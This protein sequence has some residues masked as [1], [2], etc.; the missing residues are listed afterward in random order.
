MSRLSSKEKQTMMSTVYASRQS[1]SPG[2]SSAE[3]EEHRSIPDEEYEEQPEQ[4]NPRRSGVPQLARV[5]PNKSQ[6]SRSQSRKDDCPP[7]RHSPSRRSPSRQ[8]PSQHSS[9]RQTESRKIEHSPR[10]RNSD[11]ENSDRCD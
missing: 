3:Y 2:Q 7:S 8:S 5:A 11:C 9:S 10:R 1:N 6:S 4:T